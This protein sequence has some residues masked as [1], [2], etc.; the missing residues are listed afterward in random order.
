MGI[1][2][3]FNRYQLNNRKMVLSCLSWQREKP[4]LLQRHC[5]KADKIEQNKTNECITEPETS[6]RKPQMP[7]SPNHSSEW[8]QKRISF[9]TDRNLKT[10]KTKY[11]WG[12]GDMRLT[13]RETDSD[14]RREQLVSSRWNWKRSTLRPGNPISRETLARVYEECSLYMFIS[15]N[16][17][18]I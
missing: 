5:L 15:K 2:S 7:S 1:F 6:K 13:G 12:L 4:H 8:K 14:C 9:Q 18:V 3:F 10:D 16:P 11:W 17:K